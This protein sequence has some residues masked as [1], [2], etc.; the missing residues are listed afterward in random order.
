MKTIESKIAPNP[1]E[2]QIW[3]DLSAD[4]HGTVKKIWNGKK[5]IVNNNDNSELIKNLSQIISALETRVNSIT[6]QFNVQL[7]KLNNN[8]VSLNNR[9]A[10][11]EKAAA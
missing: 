5:W 10:K 2:A 9:I 7:N 6:E 3:I 4:A 8:I 1:K 11:L